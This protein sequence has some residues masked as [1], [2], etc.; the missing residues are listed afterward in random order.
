MKSELPLF[1]NWSRFSV[2]TKNTT[3]KD[4]RRGSKYTQYR[5]SLRRLG[6]PA[7][8]MMIEIKRWRR[9]GQKLRAH[10]LRGH[11]F[12]RLENAHGDV[13][14]IVRVNSHRDGDAMW[15]QADDSLT[16]EVGDRGKQKHAQA[17]FISLASSTDNFLVGLSVGLTRKPL[18]PN[19]L[20]GIAL[21]NAVGCFVAT[22]GGSLG[23]EFFLDDRMANGIASLAFAYLA[24]RE[25]V[26]GQ[27]SNDSS[28]QTP[29]NVSLDLA[30][31]MTLNNLAGGVTAGLLDISP[32]WNFVYVLFMSVF[33]MWL[34]YGL[35]TAFS[36]LRH[37]HSLIYGP[38]CI[39]L[40]LSF[41]SFVNIWK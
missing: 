25:Y 28:S 19:V 2:N 6:S 1:E 21:C 33:T 34:G 4:P 40:A 27:A 31:P 32:T 10:R 7:Q 13:R 26:E 29:K 3:S 12:S 35:G 36:G 9:E 41:Q 5:L 8:T 15:Q 18:L 39:Y 17:L 38:I 23:A 14:P 20:W 37:H 30:L 22:S 16:V 24:V 11:V